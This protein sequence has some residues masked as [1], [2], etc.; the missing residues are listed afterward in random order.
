[1]GANI[2]SIMANGIPNRLAYRNG[3][4]RPSRRSSRAV[5]IAAG[6]RPASIAADVLVLVIG[7]T[8]SFIVH[9]VGDIPVAELLLLPVLPLVLIM[10]G[11]RLNRSGLRLI[12][13]LTVVWLLGQILTDVYR[14]TES[15]DWIRGDARIVFF[16]ID[17]F[18]VAILLANNERRRM[19]FIGAFGIGALLAAVLEPPELMA[20][21]PWKF[22]YSTGVNILLVLTS[23]FFY[24]RRWYSLTA[25]TLVGVVSINLVE[26]FRSAVLTVLIAMAL[27]IPLIPERVGRLTLLP[28]VGS[29][30]RI[31]VLALFALVGA[32]SAFGLVRLVTATGIIGEQAQMKNREQARGAGGLLLGGRPEI[33]VSSH[34][35]IDSPL[36]GHGSYA[37]DFKYVEMLADMRAEEGI[38]TDLRDQEDAGGMIPAHSHLMSAWVQAGVLGAPLWIYVFWMVLKGISRIAM[39]RPPNAPIY[40]WMLVSLAWDILFSPFGSTRRLIDAVAILIMLDMLEAGE[41]V[42]R[43]LKLRREAGIRRMPMRG[44]FAPSLR[45]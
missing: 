31:V 38:P 4:W 33:L 9:L 28:R 30:W 43:A 36:I 17:L 29:A 39:L 1:M 24:S 42:M 6:V 16:A 40:A 5:R 15:L 2:T 19:I 26:N 23:C 32:L 27:V 18:C 35:V 11:K 41:K 7:V 21:D 22:G 13:I 37:R 34:A 12:S 20:D 45:T 10:Q 3:V 8:S 44:R 14:R 25:L